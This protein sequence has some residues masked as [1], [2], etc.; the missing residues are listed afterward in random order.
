MRRQVVGCR[1][2]HDLLDCTRM[3]IERWAEQ[4]HLFWRC[5]HPDHRAR[6]GS[7]HGRF[8]DGDG[9]VIQRAIAHFPDVNHEVTVR[10][11]RRPTALPLRLSAGYPDRAVARPWG[12]VA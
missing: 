12:G 2:L 5:L 7:N 4:R 11:R 6:I 1:V 10:R 9:A 3:Q 8:V